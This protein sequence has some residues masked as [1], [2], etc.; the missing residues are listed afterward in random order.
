[1]TDLTAAVAEHPYR[2]GLRAVLARALYQAGRQVD[3]LRSLDDARRV[4]RDEIGVDPGPEL[5][6]VEAAILDHDPSLEAPAPA[7]ARTARAPTGTGNCSSDVMWSSTPYSAPP[8]PR[9]PGGRDAR[10][11]SPASPAS[12]R[13]GWSR[14][15]RRGPPRWARSV[16]WARCRKARR[17]PTGRGSKS[18]TS[19]TPRRAMP[20]EPR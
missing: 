6:A 2:E 14:S 20:F 8:A 16:A 11:C 18:P 19:S 5:R 10:S 15:C 7:P 17:P 4:L 13:P 3:A 12:A 1:M 9:S